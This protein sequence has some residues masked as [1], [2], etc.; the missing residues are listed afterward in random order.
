[1][2]L[3]RLLAWSWELMQLRGSP[4]DAPPATALLVLLL[5]LDLLITGYYLQT[6]DRPT[7][8]FTLVGRGGLRLLL[9]Y[10]LLYGF[11]RAPRFVQTAIAQLAVGILLTAILLPMAAA[12]VRSPTETDL[13]LTLLRLGFLS[14]LLWSI[15]IDGHILRHALAMNFWY[16][17]PLALLVFLVYQDLAERLLPLP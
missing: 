8:A 2:S 17:L 9:L 1:M 16:A 14:L 4:A 12:L 6:I 7:D 10:L 15:V 11:G 5:F 3:R 13:V